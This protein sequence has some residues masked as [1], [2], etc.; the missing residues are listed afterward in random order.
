MS[1]I[2][3]Y[4]PEVFH[5]NEDVTRRNMKAYDALKRRIEKRCLEI[6]PDYYKLGLRERS[7]I[8]KQ[9]ENEVR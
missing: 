6:N 2:K 8:R 3:W 5:I 4:P 9:A 7:K 1:K